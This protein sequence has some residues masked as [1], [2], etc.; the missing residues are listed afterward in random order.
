M[1]GPAHENELLEVV[2]GIHNEQT[3]ESVLEKTA[4]ASAE[5]V[6]EA[7][8]VSSTSALPVEEELEA[9]R[10]KTTIPLPPLF[11]APRAKTTI[12]LPPEP[13]VASGSMM[14]AV[15]KAQPV[16][17]KRIPSLALLILL[18]LGI[19]APLVLVA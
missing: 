7:I 12:P 4:S 9:P 14:P 15:Q 18:L 16:R 10:A 19:A 17:R 11:E 5:P 8:L 1:P 13:I 3:A 2:P 6:T